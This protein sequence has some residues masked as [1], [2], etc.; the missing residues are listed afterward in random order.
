M[1]V[2]R[3]DGT[4]VLVTQLDHSALSGELARHW[5]NARF[6]R[7]QPLESAVLAGARHDEGW[8]EQDERPLYDAAAQ[9]PMH[10]RTID[11]RIHVPFY[12]EGIR[13]IVALVE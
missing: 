10:F 9:G 1:I 11:V 4:L 12:R 2:R 6:A 8:R 3:Q 13:R 7:P 5:G